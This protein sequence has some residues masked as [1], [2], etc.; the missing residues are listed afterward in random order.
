MNFSSISVTQH[1]ARSPSEFGF[2]S[3]APVLTSPE[4][5]F[6]GMKDTPPQFL[7]PVAK[8]LPGGHRSWPRLLLLRDS[9]R[10]LGSGLT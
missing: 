8:A 10:M 4:P 1:T 2:L 6:R 3:W 7:T 5:V 9:Y